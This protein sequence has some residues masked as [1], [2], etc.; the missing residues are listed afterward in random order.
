[1]PALGDIHLD[2]AQNIPRHGNFLAQFGDLLPDFENSSRDLFL[3]LLSQFSHLQ[4]RFLNTVLGLGYLRKIVTDS[5]VDAFLSRSK[6][7]T[8]LFGTRLLANRP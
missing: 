6:L 7:S 1:M 4:L 2:A 5:T 8:R 3:K